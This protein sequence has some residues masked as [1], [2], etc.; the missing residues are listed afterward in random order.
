MLVISEIS[1]R[2]IAADIKASADAS[3]REAFEQRQTKDS[4]VEKPQFRYL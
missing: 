4:F 1:Q 2:W 3:L